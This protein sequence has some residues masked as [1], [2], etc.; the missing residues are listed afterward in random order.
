MAVVEG[1]G[2]VQ[3]LYALDADRRWAELARLVQTSR[4]GS[5]FPRTEPTPTATQLAARRLAQ[6]KPG[7]INSGC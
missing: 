2:R 1:V 5:T 3:Q 6:E 4:R 7:K